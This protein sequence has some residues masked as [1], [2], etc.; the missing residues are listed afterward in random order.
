M[1]NNEIYVKYKYSLMPH[2]IRMILKFYD[3][4]V[5]MSTC[6]DKFN[7]TLEINTRKVYVIYGKVRPR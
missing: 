6:N 5:K 3:T 7:S 4:N 2:Y 1:E